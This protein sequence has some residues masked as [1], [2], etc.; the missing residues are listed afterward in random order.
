MEI[1]RKYLVQD[2]EAALQDA[3]CKISIEQAYLSISRV[4]VVRL[5]IA[6]Q[7]AFLTIKSSSKDG[8]LSRGEWEYAIP[9]S[10]AQE[11]L[12][13]AEFRPIQKNRYC[14]PYQGFV[15]EVD[16]FEGELSGLVVAEVELQNKS[17]VPEL[18]AWIGKEVTADRRYSNAYLSRYHEI[19]SDE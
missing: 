2:L 17:D 19:P 16:V 4:S 13:L 15:W 10:E 1:E 3:T 11:M 9:L 12:S 6:D 7:E 5:R 18:P 8:G 14:V